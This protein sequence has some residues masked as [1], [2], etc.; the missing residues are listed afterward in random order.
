M[1]GMMSKVWGPPAWLFLH[2]VTMCYDPSR[3]KA[4]KLFFRHLKD[5]LPCAKCRENYS[6]IISSGPLKLKDEHFA[7]K[8]SLSEWLFRVH[9]RVQRDIY[10]KTKL[11][12]DRSLFNQCPQNKK[13]SFWTSFYEQFRAKCGT[14][15]Y[16]CDTPSNGR[17]KMS[18]IWITNYK[19]RLAQKSIFIK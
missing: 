3:K 7:S 17:R 16:G 18:T 15:V 1:M 2:C 19:C 13:T 8:E 11:N 9:D 5:V 10:Q 12:K 6:K 4:Y 14:V